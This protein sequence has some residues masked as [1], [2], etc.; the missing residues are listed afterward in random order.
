MPS[1]VRGHTD[2]RF[3]L[4]RVARG[5]YYLVPSAVSGRDMYVYPRKIGEKCFPVVEKAGLGQDDSGGWLSWIMQ[6][7]GAIS[8]EITQARAELELA[9]KMMA[10]TIGASIIALGISSYAIIKSMKE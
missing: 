10:I 8:E 9:K 6:Q 1:L 3:A 2:V 4:P 7:P 5:D